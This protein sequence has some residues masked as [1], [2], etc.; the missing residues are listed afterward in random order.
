MKTHQIENWTLDIIERVG[1]GQPVE[2]F[3]VE[4]KANWIEPIKA[5][6]RIAGHANAAKGAEILWLVGVDEGNG[7]IGADNGELAK[8]YSQVQTE[9]DGLA[10]RMV[11]DINVPIDGR[12]VVALVFETDRAPFVIKNPVFGKHTGGP[13]EREV[14]WREGT[15]VRSATRA[16]LLKILSPL[17]LL[18]NL[19]VLAA[20]LQAKKTREKDK[21]LCWW[22]LTLDLYAEPLGENRV[23]I[24]FHRCEVL[25]EL[26]DSGYRDRFDK[27]RLYPPTMGLPVPRASLTGVPNAVSETVVGTLDE[28]F[29]Y[30]PGKFHLSAQM[31]RVDQMV[32]WAERAN[33]RAFLSPVGVERRA[34]VTLELHVA[35]TDADSKCTWTTQ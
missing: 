34:E 35:S 11:V 14:P 16:D 22:S 17:Q 27:V 1:Q 19:E 5:A 28:L 21:I 6:R 30:G 20:Q 8:W 31:E 33:L 25:L 3:R 24:P 15:R 2:D 29:I 12:T 13:V 18:P 7:V 32:E 23:T 10:P 9:F 26:P 4:L